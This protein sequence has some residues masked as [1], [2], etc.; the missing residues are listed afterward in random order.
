MKLTAIALGAVLVVGACT[1]APCPV[2]VPVV[3]PTPQVITRDV[4]GP[5]V[6]VTPPACAEIL[7]LLITSTTGPVAAMVELYAAYL[8]YP[9]EDLTDFGRRA[10]AILNEA[11]ITALPDNYMG[12]YQQCLGTPAPAG[13]SG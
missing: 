9:N 7:D 11:T 1:A 5:T 12:I 10:E 2:P 8:D 13:A 6:Y 3:Q 4:P